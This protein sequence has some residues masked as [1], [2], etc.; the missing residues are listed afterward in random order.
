[1]GTKALRKILLG[2]ETTAGTAVAAACKG[3]EQPNIRNRA[4]I[5]KKEKLRFI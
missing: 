2:A 3:A 4:R 5:N 1:M